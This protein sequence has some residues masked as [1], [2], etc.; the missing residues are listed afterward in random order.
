MADIRKSL[1]VLQEAWADCTACELGTRRNLVGG[2]PV[3][4][5]GVTRGIMFIG[6]GPGKSEEA[7]GVPFQGDSGT[8]LRDI[9]GKLNFTDYYLTNLVACRACEPIIDHATGAQKIGKSYGGRPGAPLYKDQTPLPVHVTACSARL[10]EEIYLVDPVLIVA[11]GVTSAEF[12][13]KK[14]V[15]ITKERGNVMSCSIPGATLRPRLTDKKQAWGRKHGGVYEMPTEQ[16]EVAYEVLLSV[17]PSYVKRKEGDMGRNSPLSQFFGDIRMAV[18]IYE[19]YLVHALGV[20]P[21]STS[22]ADLS[23]LEEEHDGEAGT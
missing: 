1:S 10:Y 7:L 12:L 4:G 20:E 9:L 6:D 21:T 2:H 14:H 22:D 15:T 18:K 11:L 5:E 16:N 13:L 3:F 23:N 8:L 17:H 19:Y